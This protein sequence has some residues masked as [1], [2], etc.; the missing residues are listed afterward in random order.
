MT[1]A[2]NTQNYFEIF[3]VPEFYDLDLAE[4]SSRFRKLQSAIHPDKYASASD[5]ERR[6]SVQKSALINEAYLALKS[7]LER[8]RYMLKLR[9][10]DLSGETSTT[11]APDFLMQQMELREELEQVKRSQDPL[12]RLE[13]VTGKINKILD[14]QKQIVSGLFAD[15]NSDLDKIADYVRRMQFIC[16]L[17][18]EVELLEEELI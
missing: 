16:K 7:P 9:G 10:V 18:Q 4:L 15:K 14:Q 5:M 8:A 1:T 11:M 13:E 3:G 12:S 2:G 17:K 6:L